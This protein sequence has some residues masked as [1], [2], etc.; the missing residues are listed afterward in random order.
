MRTKTLQEIQIDEISANP[1]N[2]RLFWDEDLLSDLKESISKVGVLVPITV[3]ENTRSDAKTR[4]VL[5]DGERRWRCTKELGIKKI[6]ANIIDEPEDIT[7]NILYMFNIHGFRREWEIFPTALKLDVLIK[8]LGQKETVLASSTGLKISMIRD[9]KKLLWYPKK[10]RNLLMDR[11]PKISTAFFIELYPIALRLSSEN[12]YLP[13]EKL[14]AFVDCMIDKF[15]NGNSFVDVKEMRIIRKCFSYF[16]TQRNS[17][18]FLNRMKYFVENID[19]PIEVF[20]ILDGD[21]DKQRQTLIKQLSILSNAIQD[22]N[23]D[24]LSDTVFLDQ[25]MLLNERIF[26]LIE[27]ID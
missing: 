20:E 6:K 21:L 9:C 7:Q 27:K 11:D 5:L 3:F 23:P 16:D 25:L 26:K 13:G 12:D 14:E 24:L 10:Y 19:E 4:Y 2:P 18:E 15:K 8:E 22:I 1:Q 17:L